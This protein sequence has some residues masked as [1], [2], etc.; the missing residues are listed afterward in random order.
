MKATDGKPV[1]DEDEMLRVRKL[2]IPPAWT[3]VWICPEAN[4]VLSPLSLS[5]R[6]QPLQ[7][8][9]ARR[10]RGI[11]ADVEDE[12]LRRGLQLAIDRYRTGEAQTQPG[13]HDPTCQNPGSLRIVMSDK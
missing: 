9:P 13:D 7:G 2:A 3:D 11:E 4:G 1:R 6:K 8:K 12:F 10:A 5:S